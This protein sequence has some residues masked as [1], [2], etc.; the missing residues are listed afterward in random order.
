MRAALICLL[1]LALSGPGLAATPAK[2]P[3]FRGLPFGARLAALPAMELVSSH[4]DVAFYRRAEEKSLLG[5]ECVTDIRYGFSRGALFFVRMRLTGCENQVDLVRA[6]ETKYGR[7]AN[8]SAPGTLRLAWRSPTLAITLSHF[9]R[10]GRTEVDYVSLPDLSHDDREVWQAPETIRAEGPIGFR[11]LR[12]GRDIATIPGMEP[13]YREG[14]AAYYRRPGDNLDLGELRLSDILYGFHKGKL[15]T[16]V[17]RAP[18][19]E[20]FSPLRQAYNAK[21]GPPK[22][23]PATLEEDLVWSW[24]KAQIALSLDAADGGL[25]IRYADAALLAEVVKAETA[26]GAPPVISGGP[27]LF[28]RG[29]PPRSFRGATF[30]SPPTALPGAEY[31][32]GHRGRKYY[33]RAD[34]RLN[35]G[36]I[37]LTKVVYAYDDER[38]ASVTLTVAPRGG[39]PEQD[40]ERVL[41]AYTTKY[42]PAAARASE[43]G[44]RLF[45]WT[46]PGLSIALSSPKVGPLE[47]HYVD[48][49]LLRRR[50]ADLAAKALGTL[51]H[52]TFEVPREHL[53]RIERPVPQE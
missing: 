18:S 34:E 4:G 19:A 35:L 40:F 38:L 46:W 31:L 28:S 17:T 44:S 23:V 36:D 16:V 21:Y 3:E 14:A 2:G 11:G 41:S 5:E 45:L 1:V 12:F 24:P 52:K 47:I 32:F 30:G 7:P 27:R 42:G 6:Y 48:A 33:R 25:T 29:D 26:A 39:D 22:A 20:D 50:E 43:D 8:E 10:E 9:A 15:F 51:D 53:E 13:A 37:P 49:S